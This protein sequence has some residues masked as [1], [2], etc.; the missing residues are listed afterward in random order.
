MFFIRMLVVVCMCCDNNF[1]TEEGYFTL[2]NLYFNWE[3]SVA[4]LGN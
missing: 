3:F 2:W 4:D 1:T